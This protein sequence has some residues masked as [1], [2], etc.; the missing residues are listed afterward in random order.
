M[1]AEVAGVDVGAIEGVA[2]VVLRCCWPSLRERD[3][4]TASSARETHRPVP[5]DVERR[6]KEW[7]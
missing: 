1:G 3:D 7:G 2:D 4:S 5:E 6:K